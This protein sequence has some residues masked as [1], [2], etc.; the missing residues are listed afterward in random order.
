MKANF[1]VNSLNL[2]KNCVNF[3][4]NFYKNSAKFIEFLAKFYARN[5]CV[6]FFRNS[7]KF[8]EN[9]VNFYLNLTKFY[10]RIFYLNSMK[11]STKNSRFCAKNLQNKICQ[12][13]KDKR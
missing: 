5:A 10:A 2:M 13:P 7:K 11:F 8:S 6:N 12:I 1:S 4:V 9:F 3:F